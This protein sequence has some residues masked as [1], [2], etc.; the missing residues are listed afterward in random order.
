MIETQIAG[1][2]DGYIGQDRVKSNIIS[3]ILGYTNGLRLP[4]FAFFGRA[5]IGKSELMR[6]VEKAMGLA[7]SHVHGKEMKDQ[8]KWF[9][10]CDSFATLDSQNFLELSNAVSSIRPLHLY[11]DEVQSL[12]KG[13]CG[14]TKSALHDFFKQTLD[15]QSKDGKMLTFKNVSEPFRVCHKTVS[16]NIGTNYP[17]DIGDREALNRRFN[18]QNLDLYTVEQIAIITQKKLAKLGIRAD[19]R[20]LR[21]VGITGK[22]TCENPDKIS[23]KLAEIAM[24][25]GKKTV[26]RDDALAALRSLEFFPR[27]LS[28]REIHILKLC[29]DNSIKISNLAIMFKTKR[30]AINED[31]GNLMNQEVEG[32]LRPFIVE[33][34]GNVTICPIGR[35]YLQSLA[36]EKF[37]F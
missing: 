27:G 26:N 10:S 24:N 4:S 30:Q 1:C 5:G 36:E 23:E 11:F 8:S 18:V 12:Y 22:G 34:S 29:Q 6:R 2:F 13:Y 3:A 33:R 16:I 9:D 14:P 32:K 7:I 20:T 21:L 19:E 15:E 28:R 17:D 25:A 31:L 37:S 35:Q